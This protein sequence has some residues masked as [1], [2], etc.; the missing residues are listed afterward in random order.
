M[1]TG[2]VAEESVAAA[3][4]DTIPYATRIFATVSI[5]SDVDM[6]TDAVLKSSGNITVTD[7][8]S[9]CSSANDEGANAIHTCVVSAYASVSGK[10]RGTIIVTAAVPAV[11]LVVHILRIGA[12]VYAVLLHSS[13]VVP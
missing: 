1:I 3:V 8:M 12:V 5:A 6:S 10:Q 13:I 11:V 2:A 7:R 4:P 9:V